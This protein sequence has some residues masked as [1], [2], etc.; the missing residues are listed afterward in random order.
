MS[1]TARVYT[2]LAS[3]LSL[4]HPRMQSLAPPE[5]RAERPGGAGRPPSAASAIFALTVACGLGRA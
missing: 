3:R 2:A 1:G 4:H 5:E